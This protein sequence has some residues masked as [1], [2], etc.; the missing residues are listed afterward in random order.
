MI[1]Y[2]R[3]RQW[4]DQDQKGYLS[5]ARGSE[6]RASNDDSSDENNGLVLCFL[7]EYTCISFGD[8]FIVPAF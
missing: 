5:K 1:L 2:L 7:L 3:V 8:A 4:E 6:F